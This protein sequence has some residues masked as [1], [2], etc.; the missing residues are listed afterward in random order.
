MFLFSIYC[1]GGRCGL[2]ILLTG[3]CSRGPVI[4]IHQ[5]FHCIYDV[6]RCRFVWTVPVS[7]NRHTAALLTEVRLP[8]GYAYVYEQY[9]RCGGS[10]TIGDFI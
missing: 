9:W 7:S 4:I 6:N 2:M 1:V 3:I 8:Y 5:F 10:P